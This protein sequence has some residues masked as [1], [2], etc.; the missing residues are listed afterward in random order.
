MCSMQIQVYAIQ[1]I[2]ILGHGALGRATFQ[3]M[4]DNCSDLEQ[5]GV[6]YH[7][8]DPQRNVTKNWERPVTPVNW[9]GLDLNP[10]PTLRVSW[11]S[12]ISHISETELP[13]AVFVC[14]PSSELEEVLVGLVE[15]KLPIGSVVLIR[16]TAHPELLKR[17]ASRVGPLESVLQHVVYL[18]EYAT[19]R[20]LLNRTTEMSQFWASSDLADE[21]VSRRVDEYLRRTETFEEAA[22][23]KVLSNG[24]LAS[25][26][27]F[28]NAAARL[29]RSYGIQYP[30][31]GYP[32][33]N[34]DSYFSSLPSKAPLAFG[35]KCMH[36]S[37][38]ILNELARERTDETENLWDGLVVTNDGRMER[39]SVSIRMFMAANRKRSKRKHQCMVFGINSHVDQPNNWSDNSPSALLTRESPEVYCISPLN[40]TIKKGHEPIVTNIASPYA[41]FVQPVPKRVAHVQKMLFA[42]AECKLTSLTVFDPLYQFSKSD[43][44]KLQKHAASLNSSV[45]FTL[46]FVTDIRAAR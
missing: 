2:V 32:E 23:H 11:N 28:R 26:Y 19:D 27:S 9:K 6:Y 12:K 35:G 43:I 4:V 5:R 34:L 36:S 46:K 38:A 13:Y 1:N 14:V 8:V 39:M 24:R 31:L 29:Y 20:S 16:T 40:F 22:L 18:P 42:N 17:L 41:V 45:P 7:I 25:I 21:F 15:A 44:V 30:E 33:E 37:L 3:T 10:K